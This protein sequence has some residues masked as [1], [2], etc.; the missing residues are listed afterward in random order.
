MGVKGKSPFESASLAPRQTGQIAPWPF[1]M[2]QIYERKKN[3]RKGV[4]LVVS[5]KPNSYKGRQ[6]AVRVQ[7]VVNP[8]R[9]FQGDQ[10]GRS[11]LL[12]WGRKRGR[13]PFALF[14]PTL[15][16]DMCDDLYFGPPNASVP[17]VEIEGRC[18]AENKTPRH[19]LLI[20]TT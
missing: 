10:A 11:K 8:R 3:L 14:S 15:S 17:V 19:S 13:W 12:G 18:T 7:V 5:D 2:S 16:L 20:V 4:V 9:C 6:I 1:H